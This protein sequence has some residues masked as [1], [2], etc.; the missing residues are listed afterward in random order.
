VLAGH[1][2]EAKILT[3]R[4]L[5][6]GIAL[7]H[8]SAGALFWTQLSV[9]GISFAP[10]ASLRWPDL[11][12]LTGEGFANKSATLP[13]IRVHRIRK[14]LSGT[15]V[16]RNAGPENEQRDLQNYAK[17]MKGSLQWLCPDFESSRS[18]PAKTPW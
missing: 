16:S 13:R 10:M 2:A 11:L 14:P 8:D 1:E 6:F 5:L 18:T 3:E 17:S 4:R 15:S 12:V 9:Q 7:I